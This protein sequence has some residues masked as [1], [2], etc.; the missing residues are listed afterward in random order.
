V[1]QQSWNREVLEA[2]AFMVFGKLAR[3]AGAATRPLPAIPLVNYGQFLANSIS[4]QE[5]RG[6]PGL[7]IA[8]HSIAGEIIADQ[9]RRS[10]AGG[11]LRVVFEKTFL[12]ICALCEEGA[13]K[14]NLL[15]A[16]RVAYDFF[17]TKLDT[18]N[19]F[20]NDGCNH[21]PPD[22][23]QILQHLLAGGDPAEVLRPLLFSPASIL[24]R[25]GL[26]SLDRVGDPNQSRGPQIY[27]NSFESLVLQ[28]Y[29]EE[30]E[31]SQMYRQH[32]AFLTCD[33]VDSRRSAIKAAYLAL[34]SH[35]TA[36][37][38]KSRYSTTASL[39]PGV[40]LRD[41][42]GERLINYANSPVVTRT[43][44]SIFRQRCSELG[45]PSAIDFVP[46]WL[47]LA[48]T[49]PVALEDPLYKQG[50]LPLP[51]HSQCPIFVQEI[52]R[53]RWFETRFNRGVE[54][55]QN[56]DFI[57]NGQRSG[58]LARDLYALLTRNKLLL[59]KV[60]GEE[61][62]VI[63]SIHQT[64]KPFSRYFCQDV[65]T[66]LADEIPIPIGLYFRFSSAVLGEELA[67]ELTRLMID[68]KHL[69]LPNDSDASLVNDCALVEQLV[70][71]S[72]RGQVS[73]SANLARYYL[74]AEE[75]LATRRGE[76]F[77]PNQF[78]DCLK[79]LSDR[80]R[81]TV[82]VWEQQTGDASVLTLFVDRASNVSDSSIRH[83]AMLCQ[84]SL[85][86]LLALGADQAQLFR[87]EEKTGAR[88][89]KI[90]RREG[91]R[92]YFDDFPALFN[93]LLI[94]RA[95]QEPHHGENN[96]NNSLDRSAALDPLFT[97]LVS[98][99]SGSLTAL[100]NE[101]LPQPVGV[102]TANQI[103]RRIAPGF[104]P[105]REPLPHQK[106]QPI[107]LF[108][109]QLLERLLGDI[110]AR[111][112]TELIAPA[113]A[114]F[115]PLAAPVTFDGSM[116]VEGS[117][118][119][120]DYLE[121]AVAN[122][123]LNSKWLELLIVQHHLA[124]ERGQQSQTLTYSTDQSP[125]EFV[126]KV[127]RLCGVSGLILDAAIDHAERII[128]PELHTHNIILDGRS[129]STKLQFPGADQAALSR[130]IRASLS[131]GPLQWARFR[132]FNAHS[133]S[134][135]RLKAATEFYG[136]AVPHLVD[137]QRKL[138]YG[139]VGWQ[140][141]QILDARA[142]GSSFIDR[143]AALLRFLP[144]PSRSRDQEIH[145]LFESSKLGGAEVNQGQI[146]RTENLLV[147]QA[148][149][150]FD[151]E[152]LEESAFYQTIVSTASIVSRAARQHLLLWLL[153]SEKY[154]L[155]EI[156]KRYGSDKHIDFSRAPREVLWIP[157]AVREGFLERMLLGEN[158]V[159][160]VRDAA[161]RE[162]RE[163]FLAALFERVFPLNQTGRNRC[164]ITDQQLLMI[165]DLFCVALNE[166]SP[167]RIAGIVSAM[168]ELLPSLARYSFGKRIASIL[169]IMG[170]AWHKVGQILSGEEGLIANPRL[171]REL[172]T[173][174]HDSG[175][176]SNL[177]CYRSVEAAGVKAG[178]FVLGQRL[179]RASIKEVR[180]GEIG[181]GRDTHAA[182]FKVVIANRVRQMPE[183]HRAL[184]ASL[185][186]LRSQY[187]YDLTPL[188]GE[189]QEGLAEEIDLR[190]EANN[191]AQIQAAVTERHSESGLRV[192]LVVP[193]I[194]TPPETNRRLLMVEELMN[195]DTGAGF[196][197]HSPDTFA[198]RWGE[199]VGVGE[200]RGLK[201]DLRRS[202]AQE[203][204][205]QQSNQGV[206]S[207]DP[208][209]GNC[210]IVP[211]LP[212][213]GDRR[214]T[215]LSAKLA[216]IDFGLSFSLPHPFST[217]EIQLSSSRRI[218]RAIILAN[219]EMLSSAVADFL[220]VAN[221]QAVAT[222]LEGCCS[223]FSLTARL[224]KITE[225][226]GSI[227]APVQATRT[228][229]RL[230]KARRQSLW[231]NP[232]SLWHA[233]SSLKRL[234]G[235]DHITLRELS[236]S[237][238]ANSREVAIESLSPLIPSR[239][240]ARG[241]R[242]R[243]Q[244]GNKVNELSSTLSS[245]RAAAQVGN[246]V[247]VITEPR[248]KVDDSSSTAQGI[249]LP[250]VWEAP[251]VGLLCSSDEDRGAQIAKLKLANPELSEELLGEFLGLVFKYIPFTGTRMRGVPLKD[252]PHVSEVLY[253]EYSL[254]ASLLLGSE[255]LSLPTAEDEQNDN[256]RA[257]PTLG[258]MAADMYFEN[259][260]GMALARALRICTLRTMAA[261]MYFENLNGMALAREALKI[262]TG[263]TLRFGQA[264]IE[265]LTSHL[266]AR[267]VAYGLFADSAQLLNAIEAKLGQVHSPNMS[268]LL[269]ARLETSSL[270]YERVASPYHGIL[271]D[272]MLESPFLSALP[273]T[274]QTHL[275]KTPHQVAVTD[276]KGSA[277]AVSIFKLPTPEHQ[278]ELIV[279]KPGV[280]LRLQLSEE[281]YSRYRSG[282]ERKVVDAVAYAYISY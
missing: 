265:W 125:S 7:T 266:I 53:P 273:T 24:D 224:N 161:D 34:V 85:D 121:A 222:K 174:T 170:V 256:E 11:M 74:A 47:Q 228:L 189:L 214:D 260:N 250:Q 225:R 172:A 194:L 71:T 261:D 126:A 252:L 106:R 55:I 203:L 238:R 196:F 140:L 145:S 102:N 178:S 146:R 169:P 66:R 57:E 164:G 93:Q 90:A 17:S 176:Y 155:P 240:I 33:T 134:D 112:R 157:K 130:Y 27:A 242:I 200:L 25:F 153:D 221:R 21:E 267:M 45:I 226:I 246:I 105:W 241:A 60:N 107:Y 245:R 278:V 139:L 251:A 227:E 82:Q 248:S 124:V 123:E 91:A 160:E 78:Y 116:E 75:C 199:R 181:N 185:R 99:D 51:Q 111:E 269:P 244:I 72:P 1:I 44:R 216:L 68:R 35:R 42:S 198:E 56:S 58:E 14:E 177:M 2:N 271:P 167:G 59:N 50:V 22:L 258:T 8:G 101:L 89:S 131:E 193:K 46:P 187:G 94:I 230:L 277:T 87:S 144:N 188:A 9:S 30:V 97:A 249:E 40:V 79:R 80:V 255:C 257:A 119:L 86:R 129:Q 52:E 215:A 191:A 279:V 122:I 237:L 213:N 243:D 16:L 12:E 233:P 275:L 137:A 37:K 100:C 31:T 128:V 259:L 20:L 32:A 54:S 183:E 127:Q 108:E 186:R 165:K 26:V 28:G 3:A 154:P 76:A 210:I 136:T 276:R 205:Y 103:F 104:I 117:A 217:Q 95:A 148:G 36:E 171:R 206:G 236:T 197:A 204:D 120:R 63:E 113:L 219:A 10:R 73:I 6:T 5:L 109:Q 23:N 212:I 151:R 163:H 110:N 209:A 208:H 274:P 81:I 77:G 156:I 98:K 180:R 114:L 268:I 70:N 262:K 179:G 38:V 229:V 218:V 92:S 162:S 184:D 182:A 96:S 247:R 65:L 41:S 254:L 211:H 239:T 13:D 207:A 173:T 4:Q 83:A 234:M 88:N 231:V 281:Q 142:G 223:G 18:P 64:L 133:W 195:G 147:A 43:F 235:S 48:T 67:I 115:Y 190:I 19:D 282:R 61:S 264:Q 192:S 280:T 15:R 166:Y 175:N 29:R 263:V 132:D 141:W 49:T 39:D 118:D 149:R 159:L 152:M 270:G 84:L 135:E 220:G 69:R 62:T 158:G 253:R 150:E 138:R 232:L 202:L 272:Y 143:R 168:V 201:S